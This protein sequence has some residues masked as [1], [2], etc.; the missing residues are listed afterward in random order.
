MYPEPTLAT[1]ITSI[2]DVAVTVTPA[3]LPALP[4][5]PNGIL[6]TAHPS[7][8]PGVI[9]RVSGTDVSAT[10]GQPLGPGGSLA[11]SVKDASNLSAR[12]E[13]GSGTLCV[14]AQ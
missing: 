9:I 10:K 14:S 8:T 1:A 4:A 2:G 3:P 12:T 11:F 5:G 13:S 6:V 7:N